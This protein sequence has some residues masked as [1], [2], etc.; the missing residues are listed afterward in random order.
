MQII[1]RIKITFE[2]FVIGHGCIF[3]IVF[4]QNGFQSVLIVSYSLLPLKL[5]VLDERK[6]KL[7][8]VFT[9][10]GTISLDRSYHI[11]HHTVLQSLNNFQSVMNPGPLNVR[12]ANVWIVVK[13]IFQE[14][15]NGN[16]F[17]YVKF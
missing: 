14:S 2:L 16:G 7:Q 13:C 17:V 5:S 15:R 9:E 8:F 6:K 11:T 3:V 12:S 4:A 10:K 1:K